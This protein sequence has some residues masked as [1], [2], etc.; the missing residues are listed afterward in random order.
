MCPEVEAPQVL[1]TCHGIAV[2][3]ASVSNGFN[4][5]R[6]KKMEL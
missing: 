2:G 4:D 5:D 3:S 6:G 1:E